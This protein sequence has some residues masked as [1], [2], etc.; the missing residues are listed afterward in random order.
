MARKTLT[1]EGMEN[2]EVLETING[3][4]RAVYQSIEEVGVIK[5]AFAEREYTSIM[6][7]LQKVVKTLH[8][9]GN[10]VEKSLNAGA[11]AEEKK[12]TAAAMKAAMADPEKAQKIKEI[13]G[14]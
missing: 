9:R 10:A 6:L 14:L 5:G 12:A 7:N 13:L 11:V 8:A 3:I 1:V 2:T 4:E